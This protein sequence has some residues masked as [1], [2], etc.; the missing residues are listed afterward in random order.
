MMT[1]LITLQTSFAHVIG[2]HDWP[3]NIET[4]EDIAYWAY[5]DGWYVSPIREIPYSGTRLG[6][7][8]EKTS[9]LEID[10]ESRAIFGDEYGPW[11]NVEMTFAL[12]NLELFNQDFSYA[13][14]RIQF[15]TRQPGVMENIAWDLLHPA[16]E[17]DYREQTTDEEDSGIYPS[18]APS[19]PPPTSTY[20]SSALINIGVI[21]R[22]QWGATT[23]TCIPPENQ[24]YRM[25]IHHTAS[26]Q[27]M[28]GSVEQR[29]QGLQAWAMN[30]GGYCDLPYQYL[31]SYEGSIW[32][33]RP[34]D[35][36][37][38]ATG[39]NNNGNI[40]ISFIGC[41]DQSRC[42]QDY[43]FY[44]YDTDSMMARAR[45]LIQTLS[46]EH[47]IGIN[48]TNIKMHREWPGN[49]T[50]CPGNFVVDRFNELLN[51]TSYYEANVIS[52]SHTGTISLYEGETVDVWVDVENSGMWSWDSNTKLAP[53]PRDQASAIADSSWS[54]SSRVQ[55]VGGTV[56][57]TNT[58][59]FAFKIYGG[60][61][62][63]FTQNFTMLQ[64]SV[65]WFA[66]TPY[67]GGFP[68][69]S[70]T[71]TIDVQPEP[72]PEPTNE[73]SSSEPSQEPS[74]EPSEETGP[75][76]TPFAEA[77]PNQT[78]LL[79]DIVQL[80]GTNSFDAEGAPLIYN[81]TFLTPTTMTLVDET[82]PTP[83]FEASEL[84]SWQINMR[85]QDGENSSVDIVTISIIEA[86]QEENEPKQSCRHIAS[87]PVNLLLFSLI[88]FLS[89]MRR[90]Q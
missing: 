34:I 40:A 31:V 11:M 5:E 62:G 51:P 76:T 67:G 10:F 83:T 47:G 72:T 86:T 64:E 85:I 33:A 88:S 59:R 82:S 65:T 63:T 1:W 18:Y 79:G 14:R 12:P 30:T 84:G 46:N 43:G 15:R 61:V 23:T 56:D 60:Q 39:G 8:I 57:P 13:T 81:W 49:S 77:G 3:Q 52:Q 28:N 45:E 35:K 66:D 32:E 20:L 41:Y 44:N 6:L 75:N 90:R 68:D 42:Q 70:I 25:A 22:T 80:D 29:V 74:Q 2:F 73:P 71:F 7:F 17:Y 38:G 89:T 21:P 9:D 4:N 26:Q 87:N 50:A 36:Y 48:G 55:S 78:V 53:T 58:H 69:N 19:L 16:N 27:T 24:W 54:N 37:S